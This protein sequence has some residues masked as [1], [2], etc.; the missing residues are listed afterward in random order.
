[1]KENIWWNKWNDT[2]REIYEMFKTTDT[3]TL[4]NK[5]KGVSHVG[6]LLCQSCVE[7]QQFTK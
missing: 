6:T 1:M 2:S 3:D 4:K 5:A 7:V